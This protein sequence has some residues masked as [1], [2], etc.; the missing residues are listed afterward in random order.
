M[1]VQGCGMLSLHIIETLFIIDCCFDSHVL[2]RMD[3]EFCEDLN[4]LLYKIEY[5]FILQ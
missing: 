1:V 2:I 3:K 5:W 4:K